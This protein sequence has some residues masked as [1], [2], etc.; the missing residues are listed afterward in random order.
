MPTYKKK[1]IQIE[2]EQLTPQNIE[3][4]EDW[5]GGQIKG[6]SL[7]VNERVIDI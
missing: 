7:P 5:C 4:L 3:V 1:P 2:A 6:T